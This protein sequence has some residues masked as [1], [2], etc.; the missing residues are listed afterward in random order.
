M[1]PAGSAVPL[2]VL[3]AA[4]LHATWNAVAHGMKDQV[5]GF[6]LIS[7]AFTGGAGVLICL[8]PIPPPPARPFVVTSGV[9]EI[10]YLITLLNA[11]RLGD[12]TQMYPLARGLS[13]PLVTAW[14]TIV[15][16]QPLAAGTLAGVLVISLGLLG[17]ALPRGLP[18]RDQLP[19]L[20]AAIGTGVIIA[21]YTLVDGVGVRHSD[22]VLGYIAWIFLLQGLGFLVVAFALRGRTLFVGLPGDVWLRGLTGGVLSLTAYGLVVWAQSRGSLAMVAALRE[23]SIVIAAAIGALFFRERLGRKRVVASIVVVAGIALLELARG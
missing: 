14:S 18:G 3:I 1:I 15:L 13:P 20:A 11:Y 6:A 21:S 5:V 2:V 8:T 10:I 9:L 19:A 4:G 12:F 16:G 7:L 22:T 17:L 23:T